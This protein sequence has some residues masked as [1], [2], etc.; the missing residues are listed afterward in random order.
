VKIFVGNVTYKKVS[1][2]T[3]FRNASKN[4]RNNTVYTEILV[5][6]EYKL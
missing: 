3:R 5:Y 6:C 2:L 1:A 4:N